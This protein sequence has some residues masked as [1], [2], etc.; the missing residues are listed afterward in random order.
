MRMSGIYHFHIAYLEP[1]LLVATTCYIILYSNCVGQ[2]HL[3]IKEATDGLGISMAE[4][5]ASRENRC[6]LLTNAFVIC[7]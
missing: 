5:L 4:D 7:R 6:Q 2:V 3:N 1:K